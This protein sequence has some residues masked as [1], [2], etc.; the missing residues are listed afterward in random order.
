[1]KRE[2]RA[3]Y[4]FY[5]GNRFQEL[6]ERNRALE[7]YQRSVELVPT[8][9]MSWLSQGIVQLKMG[10]Y[11]EAKKIY[12]KAKSVFEKHGNQWGIAQSLND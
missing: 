4:L 2:S 3:E 8:Y 9:T 5:L 6:G 7:C 1:M 10:N 12:N 11:D